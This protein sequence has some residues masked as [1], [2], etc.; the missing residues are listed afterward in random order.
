[1]T[2]MQSRTMEEIR[3][4]QDEKVKGAEFIIIQVIIQSGGV[5]YSKTKQLQKA[6]HCQKQSMIVLFRSQP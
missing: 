4:A 1:M 2:G 5:K 6:S 3:V